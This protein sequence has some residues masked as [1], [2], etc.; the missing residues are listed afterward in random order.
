[1]R[2]R[3][4]RIGRPRSAPGTA[5][6]GGCEDRYSLYP[7]P[8]TPYLGLNHIRRTHHV[9]MHMHSV[10]HARSETETETRTHTRMHTQTHMHTCTHTHIHTDAHLLVDPPR[11][12]T[13][14]RQPALSLSIY[15]SLSI[16]LFLPLPTSLSP[17]SPSSL[18]CL[19]VKRP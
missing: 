13:A 19:N 11:R 12:D 6:A 7:L 1:M 17:A 3:E 10:R 14:V 9:H 18:P 2:E 4:R 5:R 16:S 15:L 8:L